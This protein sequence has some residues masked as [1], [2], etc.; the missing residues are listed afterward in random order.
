LGLNEFEA[1]FSDED[2][3]TAVASSEGD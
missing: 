1:Y 3:K 2:E